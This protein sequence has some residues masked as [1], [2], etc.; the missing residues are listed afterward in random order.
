ML[1]VVLAVI[2]MSAGQVNE[3]AVDWTVSFAV[4]ILLAGWVSVVSLDAL[5]VLVI[6][7]LFAT[8]PTLTTSLNSAV[9]GGRTAPETPEPTGSV[10]IVHEIVPVPP[11]PGTIQVNAGPESCLNEDSVV[12]VGIASVNTTF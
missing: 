2:V 3:H 12:F 7:V 1:H 8:L 9:W 11:I 10:A 4:D 5:A 6:V